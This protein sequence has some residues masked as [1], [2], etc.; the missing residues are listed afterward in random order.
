MLTHR[1]MSVSQK[2]INA[3]F[4]PCCFSRLSGVKKHPS[5][6]KYLVSILYIY[7]IDIMDKIKLFEEKK[8]RTHWAAEKEQWEKQVRT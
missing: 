8:V 1:L 5:K 3:G 4:T 2:P 6:L 7:Q